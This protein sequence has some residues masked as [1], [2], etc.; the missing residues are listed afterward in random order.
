LQLWQG[1]IL[2][3]SGN[4]RESERGNNKEE[5][6]REREMESRAESRRRQKVEDK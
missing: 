3:V 4:L 1:R 6:G 5:K 2:G